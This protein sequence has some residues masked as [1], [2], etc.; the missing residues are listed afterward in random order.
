M[1]G[2][3]ITDFL[4]DRIAW[5]PYKFIRGKGYR[6][7]WLFFTAVLCSLLTI[8]MIPLLML[9]VIIGYI[10]EPIFWAITLILVITYFDSRKKES[11]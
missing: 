9:G 2:T 11:T 4:L 8:G 5:Y 10:L 6:W 3:C 1:I 7:K